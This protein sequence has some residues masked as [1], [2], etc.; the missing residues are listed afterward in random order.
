MNNKTVF[1]FSWFFMLSFVAQ[2]QADSTQLPDRYYR[3][4]YDNDFFLATDR[5]YTQGVYLEFIF[6][7]F[8]KLLLSHALITLRPKGSIAG[9]R[10]I[11]YYGISTERQG[12][13]PTSIR[14]FGKPDVGE[15]PYAA[16]VYLTHSL[17]S[18][19][20]IRKLRLTSRLN[21]GLMG[22]NLFGEEEQV[23]IHTKLGNI[24]PLG[25]EYQIENDY[26]LN[27]D[28]YLEKGI[29]DTKCFT[30]TGF[31]ELRAG[32]L[33]D[34]VS[35]GAMM[36]IGFMQKY[37]S[38]LGITRQKQAQKFQCYLFVKGKVKAV[39]YNASMQGGLINQNSSYVLSASDVERVVGIG[40][41]GMVIA[42][43]RI[44]LE[45]SFASITKE[46]KKGKNHAWG[47]IGI[48]VCF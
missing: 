37:F 42:Y 5:Y 41:Y 16:I 15:R 47:R 26:V 8:K 18:I 28:V 1:F 20:P 14:H 12:F 27:Y 40:Y 46:Y 30:L 43:K 2:S 23:A 3:H 17:V 45:Y 19:D 11:N 31:T 44:G 10:V 4:N 29:V 21:L 9:S 33:Y 6:P 34:D 32:T 24:L 38:N 25:W 48:N 22:P 13:T 35:L 7:A 36:R 39:G